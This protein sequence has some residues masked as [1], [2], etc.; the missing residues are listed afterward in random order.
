[1][2]KLLA[3]NRIVTWPASHMYWI[4]MPFVGFSYIR[5]YF[6]KI[7]VDLQTCLIF[8]FVKHQCNELMKVTGREI[9]FTSCFAILAYICFT[10]DLKTSTQWDGFVGN[11]SSLQLDICANFFNLSDSSFFITGSFPFFIT[12]SLVLQKK[13]KK[14]YLCYTLYRSIVHKFCYHCWKKTISKHV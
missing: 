2:N 4:R 14:K 6:P 5:N 10:T 7:K 12:D 9:F 8:F 1:M 11:I 13:K 3:K